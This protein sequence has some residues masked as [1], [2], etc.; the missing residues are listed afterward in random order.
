MSDKRGSQWSN[1]RDDELS[2]NGE[3]ETPPSD[4][5]DLIPLRMRLAH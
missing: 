3:K 2:E 4:L 1:R 5:I